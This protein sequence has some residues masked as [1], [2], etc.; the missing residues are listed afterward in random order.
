MDQTGYFPLESFLVRRVFALWGEVTQQLE[1]PVPRFPSCDIEP[2]REHIIRVALRHGEHARPVN[3]RFCKRREVRATVTAPAN[4]DFWHKVVSVAACEVS[5]SGRSVPRS[6]GLAGLSLIFANVP[7]PE[8]ADGKR[9]QR[10]PATD[11]ARLQGPGV[12][13]CCVP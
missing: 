2:R 6:G 5:G 8:R 10:N 7:L 4:V 1:L 13:L 9:P 11:T 3:E 12:C